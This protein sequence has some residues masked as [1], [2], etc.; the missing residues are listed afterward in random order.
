M[1]YHYID[2]NNEEQLNKE[3]DFLCDYCQE[4]KPLFEIEY[5]KA[6]DESCNFMTQL[7]IKCKK[8]FKNEQPRH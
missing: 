7:E 2:E 1:K 6:N 8:C 3:V 4:K 5:I